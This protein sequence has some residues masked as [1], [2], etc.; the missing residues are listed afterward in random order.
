MEGSDLIGKFGLNSLYW[1]K[2]V[3]QKICDF[4][5]FKLREFNFKLIHNLVPCGYSL[6]KWNTSVSQFCF[7]C[8][9]NET[10]SHMLFECEQIKIIWDNISQSV[11]F[12]I[13]LKEII[14]GYTN[15]DNSK[16]VKTI[17]YII[18]LVAYAIFKKNSK[19]KFENIEYKIESVIYQIINDI[20]SFLRYI[21]YIGAERNFAMTKF[22]NVVE[23]FNSL[24]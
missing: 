5:Y 6:S 11:N 9:H 24:D 1:C 18:T 14:C 3:N 7:L 23:F 19:C 8:D 4:E 13:S 10:V 12:K 16:I 20:K 22:N 21:H 17:N 2:M 15:F